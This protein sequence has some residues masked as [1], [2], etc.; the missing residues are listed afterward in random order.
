MNFFKD[1]FLAFWLQLQNSYFEE[2][3]SVAASVINS[4]RML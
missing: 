4:L 1:A 2:I 3:I